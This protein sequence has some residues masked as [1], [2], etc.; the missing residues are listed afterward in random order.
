MQWRMLEAREG[1]GGWWAGR[2]GAVGGGAPLPRPLRAP[3]SMSPLPGRSIAPVGPAPGR[4]R[5][6]G[7]ASACFT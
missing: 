4:G 7:A 6:S 3:I 1:R 5:G 2:A